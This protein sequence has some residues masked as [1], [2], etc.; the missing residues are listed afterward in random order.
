[1]SSPDFSPLAKRYAMSRPGYPPALFEHVAA[2]VD[3]HEVAWDCA[4]GNGQA[5][6][7]LAGHFE[8][9]IATDISEEQIRHALKNPRVDYRVAQ[10][11]SSGLDGDSVDLIAVASAVHWF[12]LEAF[13]TEAQR[14]LRHGGVLALWT[15]HVGHVEPPFDRVF[16]RFYYDILRPFF[17]PRARLVDEQYQTLVLPGEPLDPTEKFY[18]TAEW[19]LE[20]IKA[21]IMSWSGA[22]KYLEDRGQDPI[23]NISHELEALWGESDA[24]HRVRWP[25]FVR[26]ARL[27]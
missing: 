5:A 15:Y 22:Q 24:I 19:N 7:G 18:V 17:A 25:L 11:D 8:R 26:A 14:V 1:M 13:Q 6:V 3:R 16:Y 12:D 20:Q 9:V 4:T 27:G 21:F 2:L 23:D 10:S